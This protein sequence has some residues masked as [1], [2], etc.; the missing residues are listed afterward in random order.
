MDYKGQKVER[1]ESQIVEKSDS[2]A[3]KELNRI[4][5]SYMEITKEQLFGKIEPARHDDF[6]L[7]DSR[8]ASR[9]GMYMHKEAYA[10]FI[11]M[12]AAAAQEGVILTIISAMRTFDHQ[13]RIWENKWNGRQVLHGNIRA[14]S[15]AD[16][17]Q[18]ALEILRFSAMPGTSRHHWG[19][20][21]DLNSLNNS[22]FASGEGRRVYNWLLANATTFG[23]CQ[24]YTAHGEGRTAGYEAEKWHWSYK[25]VAAKFLEVFRSTVTIEDIGGFD[26]RETASEIGVIERFVLDVH[27]DCR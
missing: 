8:Y 14:T 19:T 6:V 7:I 2:I 27:A 21:I 4:K 9:G 18:R 22:Y 12:H 24:P 1:S 13:R 11:D 23:F 15:I 26:G 10:A 5:I 16:P 20:D 25:P 3:D 17:V